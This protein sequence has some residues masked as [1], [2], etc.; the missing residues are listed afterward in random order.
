[1]GP[2]AGS[3][4]YRFAP[5]F[6]PTRIDGTAFTDA[7]GFKHAFLVD[8]PNY[9]A[10]FFVPLSV[11]LDEDG[12]EVDLTGEVGFDISLIDRDLGDDS[13][14]VA[15]WSNTGT[16]G[17]SWTNMDDCGM[18]T[19]D[20]TEISEFVT[21]INLTDG[22]ITEN[23]GTL[24]IQAEVLPE[25]ASNKSLRWTI[26]NIDGKAT[27]DQ[28]GVVT[29]IIDGDVI[30][31]AWAKDGSYEEGSAYVTISNQIVSIKE[32]NVIRNPYFDEVNADG[33]AAG[34]DNDGG[35]NNDPVPYV[36]DGILVCTPGEPAELWN[37]AFWQ[38]GLTAEQDVDYIYRFV[39]WADETRTLTTNF[40]DTEENDWNRYG[41]SEDPRTSWGGTESDWTFDITPERTRYEFIVRFLSELMNENTVQRVGFELGLSEVDTYFDSI[42]LVNLEDFYRLT[43]YIP[44]TD[45][46][47]TGADGATE[48]TL[49]ATLQMSAEVLPEEA[50]Y[51]SV[52]WSVV[53]GTGGA[54]IDENGLLTPE[55][56]GNVTVVASAVDD[57]EVSG[58]LEVTIGWP[59]GISPART[60]KLKVYPN[61]AVNEL[62]IVL[63]RENSKVSIYNSVGVKL[64][65]IVVRGTEYRF[66][67]GSYAPGIYF[68]KS[69]NAVTKFVK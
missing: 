23:N 40:E 3:G 55:S 62:N 32:V 31:T 63:D 2:M 9:T 51:R 60:N 48:V 8:D 24:Q 38:N 59:E 58:E 21:D 42:E 68:I 16:I 10:E 37:Y 61:P 27:I 34:W 1:M 69:G 57:S 53:N 19:F 17:S 66:D 47:V 30:V 46:T 13:A 65:E 18:I 15:V 20:D 29:A 11:L 35:V 12:Y 14:R 36:D 43:D 33:T 25:N 26:E 7:N 52:K 41:Y 6:D 4:H 39:A 28:D 44:V 45:I 22:E 5:S 50:D 64:E 54:S 56:A 67:I 49:D